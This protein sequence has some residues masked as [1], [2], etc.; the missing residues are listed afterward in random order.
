MRALRAASPDPSDGFN[1]LK[2]S[3]MSFETLLLPGGKS[4]FHLTPLLS[5]GKGQR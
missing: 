1:R 3:V 2:S 4:S 5:E